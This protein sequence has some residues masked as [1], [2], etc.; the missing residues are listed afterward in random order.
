MRAVMAFRSALY[1]VGIV[2]LLMA[3]YLL[4]VG[5]DVAGA[6]L[7]VLSLGFLVALSRARPQAIPTRR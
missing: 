3:I 7:A 4:L 2:V 6:I 1:P 5:I